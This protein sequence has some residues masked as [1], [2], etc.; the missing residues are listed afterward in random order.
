MMADHR[1]REHVYPRS[2]APSIRSSRRYSTPPAPETVRGEAGSDESDSVK[3]SKLK[4]K[5][6]SLTHSIRHGESSDHSR[7]RSREDSHWDFTSSGIEDG[8]A[9]QAA[10]KERKLKEKAE[11]RERKLREK[12]E[13]ARTREERKMEETSPV[14]V[15]TTDNPLQGVR[16]Y[17][18]SPVESFHSSPVS[19]PQSRAHPVSAPAPAPTPARVPSPVSRPESRPKSRAETT[20]AR[21]SPQVEY[22]RARPTQENTR[23]VQDNVPTVQ[24]RARTPPM[25]PAIVTRAKTP[26]QTV[27]VPAPVAAMH[28]R[29]TPP[30]EKQADAKPVE[31]HAERPVERPVAKPVEKPAPKPV[32]KPVE[33]PIEKPAEKPIP[34]PILKPAAVEKPAE[35]LTEK[36]SPVS[37]PVD[38]PAS[39]LPPRP[40]AHRSEI[41]PQPTARRSS[42]VDTGPPRMPSP[43]A[44]RPSINRPVE[45]TS[46]IRPVATTTK[47][48]PTTSKRSSHN[49]VFP[50]SGPSSPTQP[51]HDAY[52]GGPGPW[53]PPPTHG[54][55]APA[56]AP[57]PRTRTKRPHSFSQAM[58]NYAPPPMLEEDEK[59]PRVVPPPNGRRSSHP[60]PMM[61]HYNV[62]PAYPPYGA[63]GPYDYP[64][65][66]EYPAHPQGGPP[67]YNGP[68][69]YAYPSPRIDYE[70]AYG[71]S[72]PAHFPTPADQCADPF[73]YM[74]PASTQRPVRKHTP[75]RH[76]G[77]AGEYPPAYAPRV[78]VNFTHGGTP[79][80]DPHAIR[81]AKI[82]DIRRNA[83][84]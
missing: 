22:V 43:T 21:K 61:D 73:M 59:T 35:K 12:E 31:R 57:V 56:P 67:P 60:G 45:S 18:A 81:H 14:S 19:R 6:R 37:K 10:R 75:R 3:L 46:T 44:P 29:Q 11:K 70:S 7:E 84:I 82:H 53:Y 9:A 1:G 39:T 17:G 69:D 15:D 55:P 78:D 64:P 50:T 16:I 66:N 24:A 72:Q 2:Q 48:S 26:P 68:Y 41:A 25:V 13:R 38:K 4:L 54:F 74:D 83:K 62:G 65:P 40:P 71:P 33:K 8:S 76:A 47:M 42:P 79:Q 80:A 20:T 77:K 58:V 23:S 52:Y 30:V 51:K 49:S 32:E 34:R 27:I 36:P 5:R 63:P 28:R